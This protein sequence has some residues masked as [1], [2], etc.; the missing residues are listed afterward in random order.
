MLTSPLGPVV[1]G[2]QGER[3]PLLEA[4]GRVQVQVAGRWRGRG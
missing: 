1:L 2:V 4:L 3:V